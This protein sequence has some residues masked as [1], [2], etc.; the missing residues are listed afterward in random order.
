MLW[1][2]VVQGAGMPVL[3]A[4]ARRLGPRLAVLGGSLLYSA[5][6]CL[7]ALTVT[8]AF[9]AAVASLALHGAAFCLVY[10]TTIRTAQAWF[11][12]SR[13]GLVA[14]VVV[15]GYGFG[16]CLWTP[17]QTLT[18]NP[19]NVK[20]GGCFNLTQEPV[21]NNFIFVHIKLRF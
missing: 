20:A 12:A 4:A 6:Y 19:D 2:M 15:S 18:V 8:Y 21:S 13:R 16:S 5:G 7:T 3:G 14:A 9:P 11:P 17:I 1:Q 10:A